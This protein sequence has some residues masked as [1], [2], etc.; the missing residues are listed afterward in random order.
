M[1]ISSATYIQDVCNKTPT[2]GFQGI[3]TFVDAIKD[4]DDITV[5]LFVQQEQEMIKDISLTLLTA[6]F[7]IITFPF[8]FSVMFGD[9]GHGLI[10]FLFGL[11]MV[12]SEK[13]LMAKKNDDEVS[14]GVW[15]HF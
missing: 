3:Q 15:G 8:L 5:C 12:V 6:P 10:M 11:W 1:G 9:M 7:A 14:K 13:S 2:L 4:L